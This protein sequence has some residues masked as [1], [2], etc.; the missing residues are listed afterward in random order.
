MA[1]PNISKIVVAT[2]F[3][4]TDEEN[5][6]VEIFSDKFTT[7]K[8]KVERFEAG[9]LLDPI[10]WIVVT[11]IGKEIAIGFLNS[12]GSDIWNSLKQ[13]ISKKASDKKYP[14]VRFSIKKTDQKIT[15]DLRTD[16]PKLIEKG[17]DTFQKALELVD[18]QEEKIELFFDTSTEEWVKEAKRKIVKRVE[19]ICAAANSP[20]TKG[21]KTI[22]FRKEDL[23][24]IAESYEGTPL[25]I[26]HTG[27]PIG[28]ITRTWVDDN[29]VRFEAGI[30]EGLTEDQEKDLKNMKGVSMEFSHSEIEE[31]SDSSEEG[32]G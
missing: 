29:L 11:W 17:M 13:K 14:G 3:W 23:P 19:G 18:K 26:G 24:K 6:I 32:N 12:I 8:Q 25:V 30:F 7:E 27:R 20:V 28:I 4:D 22:M 1:N 31:N 5:E 2:E 16:N 15:L 9:E 10:L 21:G